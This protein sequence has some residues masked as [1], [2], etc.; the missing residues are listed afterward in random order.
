MKWFC[1]FSLMLILCSHVVF[2]AGSQGRPVPLLV[3]RGMGLRLELLT[4][5]VSVIWARRK[6]WIENRPQFKYMSDVDCQGVCVRNF[7]NF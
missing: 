5:P 2:L 4:L 6:S 3:D 7:Y 1:L